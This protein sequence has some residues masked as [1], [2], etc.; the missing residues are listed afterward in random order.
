[1]SRID[2]AE[3]DHEITRETDIDSSGENT[4]DDCGT[5]ISIGSGCLSCMPCNGE[6]QPGTEECDRCRLAD[7]CIAPRHFPV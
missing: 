1:M 7:E 4:C 3:L 2:K 6:Y 5:P